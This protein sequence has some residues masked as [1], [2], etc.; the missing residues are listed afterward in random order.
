LLR[1]LPLPSTS[2]PIYTSQS[3]YPYYWYKISSYKLINKVTN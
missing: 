2:L 1:F 3:P